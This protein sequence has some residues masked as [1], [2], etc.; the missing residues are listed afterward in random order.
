[1]V[2]WSDNGG[3][4]RRWKDAVGSYCPGSCLNWLR[5]DRKKNTPVWP[6]PPR[7]FE[8]ANS[9]IQ[10]Q[11]ITTNP[12]SSLCPSA[13]LRKTTISLVM[14]VRPTSV[15]PT[16]R[17]SICLELLASH[18]TDFH[19]IWYLNIFRNTVEKIQVSLKS[20]KNTGCIT[21]RSLYV[22]NN[23]SLSS[24]YNE[25][26][27]RRKFQR[28]SKTQILCK[29]TFF[30]QNTC[31]LWDNLEKYGRVGLATNGN[32]IRRMCFACWITKTTDTHSEYVILIAFPL[33][34]WIRESTTKLR[35][36][37]TLS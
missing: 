2:G 21:W 30:P 31:R 26:Y 27:F 29:I 11:N 24:S 16:A 12:T 18:W 23:I 19:E 5:K 25:K 9:L 37:Y 36:P 1:M 20:D 33:Q 22:C 3:L 34:Q 14:C 13:K 15:R 4:E 6:A 28:K 10:V 7:K 8:Q 32:K 17:P 35:A